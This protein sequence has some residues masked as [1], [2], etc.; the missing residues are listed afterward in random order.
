MFKDNVAH[1]CGRYGLRVFHKIIPY[2][3]A[4]NK[5]NPL[6]ALFENFIGFKC[7]RNGAIY[8]N[9][10]HVISKN[11]KVADNILA[12]IEYGIM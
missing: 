7:K 2:E 8:E 12:G 4:F 9:V 10:G 5:K 1:S 6:L 3:D 11:F